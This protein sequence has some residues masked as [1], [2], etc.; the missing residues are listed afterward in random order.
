MARVAKSVALL[1]QRGRM[2]IVAIGATNP[3]VV[4]FALNERTKHI[5]FFQYLPV[6]MID[7]GHQQGIAE[8]VV[9]IVAWLE[10]ATD[11]L[12]PGVASCAC[13]NLNMRIL[14]IQ[15]G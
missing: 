7:A 12:L 4:H 10:L 9:V 13:L 11:D 14:L 15:P 6:G 8:M 5:D 1:F 3:L 2:R